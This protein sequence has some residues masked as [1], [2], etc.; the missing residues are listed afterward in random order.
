MTPLLLAFASVAPSIP[1][2]YRCEVVGIIVEH[3]DPTFA[4]SGPVEGFVVSLV[5]PQTTTTATSTGGLRTTT[6][7]VP[8]FI[9]LDAEQAQVL[10]D[11]AADLVVSDVFIDDRED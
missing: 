3:G 6:E 11:A 4:D 7:D 1:A 8:L 10:L 5:C 9:V 2:D